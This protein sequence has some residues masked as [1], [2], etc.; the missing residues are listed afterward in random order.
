[1]GGFVIGAVD[2]ALQNEKTVDNNLVYMVDGSLFFQEL[3]LYS[4]TSERES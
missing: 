3:Y 2:A 1:M 4:L